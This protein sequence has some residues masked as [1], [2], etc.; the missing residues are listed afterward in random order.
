MFENKNAILSALTQNCN[1][2]LFRPQNLKNFGRSIGGSFWRR[3][4][5]KKKIT[6]ANG[7]VWGFLTVIA[8]YSC[9]IIGRFPF[10]AAASHLRTFLYIA[11][12]M[13]WGYSVRRRIIQRQS[14]RY[15]T[16]IAFLI[17]FWLTVRTIKYTVFTWDFFPNVARYLWYLYYLPMLFIPLLTAFTAASI[18]KR[19]N[20]RTPKRLKLLYIPVATL[21]LLVM[22][23]DIHQWVFAFPKD[24]VVWTDYD[25]SYHFAAYLTSAEFVICAAVT[26]AVLWKKCRIP[27]RR[28]RIWAPLIPIC[29]LILYQITY[30]SKVEWLRVVFGDMTATSCVL[31]VSALELCIHYGLISSNTHYMELFDAST[32]GVRIVDKDFN[33]LL[34]SRCAMKLDRATLQRSEFSP[35]MLDGNIR[36]SST[37]IGAGYVIWTEDMT[38]LI[39]TISELENIKEELHDSNDILEEDQSLRKKEAQI[40]QQDRIYD[41]IGQ[42][43]AQQILLMDALIEQAENAGGEEETKRVLRKIVVLGAYL[44]RRS[45]LVFLAEKYPEIDPGELKLT[46]GESMD[47]LELCGTVCGFHTTLSEKIKPSAVIAVYDLFEEITERSFERMES[48]TV[49]ADK[50]GNDLR[51][52]IRTD[53]DADLS[54]L[55]AENITVERDG[56]EQRIILEIRA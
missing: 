40:A 30:S 3:K 34:S 44:K 33:V 47:N 56:D 19:E 51:F 28:K 53:S 49:N 16:I 11:L 32:I 10:G 46:I 6:R 48:I 55:A 1:L 31:Y 20:Y 52:I 27:D 4:L 12:F 36:L 54:D 26:F 24:A 50:V 14:R 41:M 7:A 42:D 21:F 29:L 22:T 5:T 2:I 43:T 9:R 13:M 37:K 17:V 23:N 25:Y 8:A 35:V 38:A 18:G 45:N 39:N 15:V